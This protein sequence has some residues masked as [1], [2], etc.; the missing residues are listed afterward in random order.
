MDPSQAFPVVIT[1]ENTSFYAISSPV[2]Y[3]KTTDSP[4][5]LDLTLEQR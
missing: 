3:T 1:G 4:Q 5:R 2:T